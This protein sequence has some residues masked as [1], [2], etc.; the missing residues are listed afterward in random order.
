[1]SE[2]EERVIIGKVTGAHGVKGEVRVALFLDDPD[3]LRDLP[4]LTLEGRPRREIKVQALRFHQNNA[5]LQVEGITDRTA[6]E[7]LRGREVSLPRSALPVLEDGE[8]YVAQLIGLTVETTEGEAL[9]KLA[10][11]MFTGANE[12]YIIRGG[13]HGEILLPAIE[14]VVQEVNLESGRIIVIVPDGLLD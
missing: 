9:G 6:A 4:T 13:P 2:A 11:V 8:Y 12:V 3:F 10:E 5:L 7:Q 14:S 1:M